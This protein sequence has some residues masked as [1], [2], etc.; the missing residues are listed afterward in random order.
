VTS[1]GRALAARAE[2]LLNRHWWRARPSWLARLLQPLTLLY[3]PLADLRRR[4]MQPQAAPV[5]VLVVGNLIVGGA[6]KT[7]AVIALV[8]AL[9]DAGHRPGVIS[10]GHGRSAG[11]V[12]AVNAGDA[13]AEVG[14]EPLLIARRTGVPLWVGRQRLAAARALCAAHTEVDVL[15]CDDGLQHHALAR[16]AELIVF[17]ERG[18]GNGL[19]LPAGPLREALP[20]C[21]R[22][23]AR[24]LYT[25]ARA[26]TPLAG[27]LA[28]RSLGLA[29]P[30]Q[31][32]W[33]GQ[34]QAAVP[35]Q[36][37]RGRRVVAA[38]GLAAPEKFFAMLEAAGLD[39]QRL[40]LPDH[41]AYQTLP[42]AADTADVVTTEKD[43]VKLDP[44]R[45]A[46]TRVWVLPLDLVLPEALV[47]D[48]LALLFTPA[49]PA[50]P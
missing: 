2:A 30:L 24:V 32:W 21:L 18:T 49:A 42:W 27:A 38:A 25:G 8:Q 36:T 23:G 5:P 4:R 33:D 45:M 14:D 34:A 26:S 44:A 12:R 17:D 15:V 22:P 7:P 16:Q 50:C 3:R 48:L 9:R 43:A 37:L 35:L 20:A 10:R 31:A 11:T 47:A 41:H 1:V 29:W 28:L 6:G 39:I 13:V 40:P 19:L 46:T